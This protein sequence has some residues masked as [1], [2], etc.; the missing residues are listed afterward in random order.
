MKSKRILLP[1]VFS[2]GLAL[3]VA[4][5]IIPPEW[6]IMVFMLSF[7]SGMTLVWYAR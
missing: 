7:L 4:F 6:A 3:A 1:I 5:E 2:F